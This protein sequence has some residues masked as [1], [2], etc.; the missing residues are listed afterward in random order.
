MS[1]AFGYALATRAVGVGPHSRRFTRLAGSTDPAA[2]ED[3]EEA[4]GIGVD[5]GVG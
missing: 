4:T 2:Q 1:V 5:Q 3:A